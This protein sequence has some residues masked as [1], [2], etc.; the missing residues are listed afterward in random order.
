[1]HGNRPIEMCHSRSTTAP[2]VIAAATFRVRVYRVSALLH[3]GQWW[4][5]AAAGGQFRVVHASVQK[6][7]SRQAD[8]TIPGW[9]CAILIAWDTGRANMD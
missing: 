3:D 6:S 8:D 7:L 4:R 1:M 9:R 5:M 2:R